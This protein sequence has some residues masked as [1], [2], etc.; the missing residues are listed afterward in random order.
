MMADRS[1]TRPETATLAAI[2]LCLC[3]LL[4]TGL[5]SAIDDRV[6]GAEPLWAKPMKFAASFGLHLATLLVLIHLTTRET[7]RGWIAGGALSALSVAALL[8]VFYVAI[9][10]ARGRASHFNTETAFEY[11]MYYAAMGGAAL[12]IV[13]MT[14]IIG[15]LALKHPRIG[16]GDGLRLGGGW[17]AI[18]SAIA[19]LF[20]GGAMA[21][22]AL[23]GPDPLIGEVGGNGEWLPLVGWSQNVGDLR[24][25]HFF[26]TH[27]F[28]AAVI[29]GWLAD[30]WVKT[31]TVRARPQRALVAGVMAVGVAV[32]AVTF[33]QALSGAPLIANHDDAVLSLSH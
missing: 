29:A 21:S 12:V 17:G 11:Y 22:G 32:T 13:A 24:V 28:Q 25:P 26:A 19:T 5:A 30:L 20:V 1:W 14:I 10:A 27:I 4:V 2:A 23:S 7:R 16:V 3:M 33:A 31:S 18:V 9:Q 6:L 15:V 8:E